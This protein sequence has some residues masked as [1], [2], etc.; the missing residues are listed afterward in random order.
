MQRF[1]DKVVFIS[2]GAKGQGAVEAKMFGAENA[3]V[4]IGDILDDSGKAL[5][6]ELTSLGINCTY[7]HLDVTNES[8]WQ[9]AYAQA[10]S[11][12]S[13]LDILINN[14]GIVSRSSITET[15]L[16]EWEKVLSVNA[17][18]S[19]IGTK[20][21]V[22]IMKDLGGG[23]IVN[24]SSTGGLV[25]SPTLGAAYASSKAAMHLLTKTTALQYAAD[26]IRCN[27]VHPGPIDT[28]MLSQIT[29]NSDLLK[30]YEEKIPLGRLG[31]P[32]EVAHAVLFLASDEASFI[33][34]TELIIDGGMLAQ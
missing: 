14:A 23:S 24:I 9:D 29:S 6:K 15:S 22:P 5:E 27:S 28:D 10:L 17:T 7:L 32:E 25:S 26:N 1:S 21:G 2:G 12:Y 33:T 19:F 4:I 20:L 30:K 11:K 18:G 13:G 16:D 3:K 34:G 8:E 31:R